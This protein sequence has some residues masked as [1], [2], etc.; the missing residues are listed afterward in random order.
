[1]RGNKLVYL[2]TVNTEPWL[3]CYEI[4]RGLITTTSLHPLAHLTTC[5]VTSLIL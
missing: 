5:S 3:G 4:R 2:F 1:M